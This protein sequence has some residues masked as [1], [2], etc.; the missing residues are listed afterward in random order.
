MEKRQL[1]D[2]IARKPKEVVCVT[3]LVSEVIKKSG[4]KREDVQTVIDLLYD[5]IS[6]S[7]L[8]KKQVRLGHLGTIYPVIKPARVGTALHGGRKDPTKVFVPNMWVARFNPSRGFE[9][10]IKE[11]PVSEEEIESIYKN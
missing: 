11:L 4:F 6:Q 1:K 8:L 2:Q 9:A 10:L 5:E 3:E 7:M